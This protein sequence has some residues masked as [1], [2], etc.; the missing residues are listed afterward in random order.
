[1]SMPILLYVIV[2]PSFLNNFLKIMSGV[3]VLCF[4]VI[5]YPTICNTTL[6]LMVSNSNRKKI[7]NI[8]L[9]LSIR[10]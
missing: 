2:I 3:Y 1:M 9:V 8:K 10:S 4:T 6:H 7:D 5:S